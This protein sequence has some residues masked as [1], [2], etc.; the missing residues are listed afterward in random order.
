MICFSNPKLK[1]RSK[2]WTLCHWAAPVFPVD[3][4]VS[5]LIESLAIAGARLPKPK[6]ID[7]YDDDATGEATVGLLNKALEVLNRMPG[8]SSQK[9]LDCTRRYI[10]TM[11][12]ENIA[13]SYFLE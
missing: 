7:E 1:F 12:T 9:A 13:G 3:A 6:E 10:S 11:K 4:L 8:K 2:L 5:S